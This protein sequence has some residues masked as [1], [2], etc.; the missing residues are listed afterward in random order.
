[1][2]FLTAWFC[3]FAHRTHLA[4]EHLQLSY[5]WVEAL[6][7]YEEKSEF[8]HF[9]TDELK[10]SNPL[11]TVPV[12]IEQPAGTAAGAAAVGAARMPRLCIWAGRPGHLCCWTT[13]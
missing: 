8:L 3:P 12:L 6:G 10:A 5:D 13:S 1:M 7:W 9:K 4:L 2:R 11:G